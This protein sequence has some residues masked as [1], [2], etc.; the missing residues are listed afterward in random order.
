MAAENAVFNSGGLSDGAG[1]GQREREEIDDSD[2]GRVMGF[3]QLAVS[4]GYRYQRLP[5]ASLGSSFL[6]LS[7]KRGSILIFRAGHLRRRFQCW[8]GCWDILRLFD[9]VP[10]LLG[11]HFGKK[12]GVSAH[13]QRIE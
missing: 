12:F 6:T 8:P 3:V 11:V 13:Q 1:S 5:G 2:A 4:S 7:G 9:D 10:E